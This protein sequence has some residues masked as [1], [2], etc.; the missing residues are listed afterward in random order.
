MAVI[1]FVFL[2]IASPTAAESFDLMQVPE[3]FTKQL[4]ASEPLVMDPVSFCFDDQGHILVAESFRQEHGVP[5]NRSSPFWLEDDLASQTIEDRLA[6]FE[7]WADQRKNGMDFYTDKQERIRRLTDRDKD[8]VFDMAKEF[9]AGFNDPLDGTGAGVLAMDGVVWF[10]NIPHL[11]RLHDFDEDGI[12]DRREVMYMGFGVRVALRGHDLHGL[13]L[14]L[15]GRLYWSIGDRGYHLELEDGRIFHSPGEGGVFRCELDGSNLEVFHHGLRNPQELAFDNFGNLFTGDNNSDDIDKARLVYCV[16]GG[17][18][19]WRMEYQTLFGD[20][21]RGPWVQEHG[22]DP[23]AQDRPAWILPAVDT[24]GSGPSGLVAYPGAGFPERYDN[25]FFMCDFR[26]AASHSSVLSFAVEPKGAG[27]TMVDLHP[28]V[29]HVLCTDVDFSYDGRMVV[30]DWG[31]GWTGNKEGRLYAAWSEEHVHEGDVS[32][33]F[34][35]GF[36]H[37]ANPEL[38]SMLSHIDRRVRIRSQL[39][40]AERDAIDALVQALHADDLLGR[41]HAMWGLAMTDRSGR[42]QMEHIV[43]LLKDPNSE[44]RAQACH[45]L[46]ESTYTDAFDAVAARIDDD[47]PRVSYFATIAASHLGNPENEVVAMVARNANKDVYLRHAGVVALA[48]C[49][50]QEALSSRTTHSSQAVRLA[51]VLALRKQGSALVANYLEDSDLDVATEAARAIHDVPIQGA[52]AALASSLPR[53][54]GMPWQRRAISACMRI[55]TGAEQVA[56]FAAD[57]TKN[58]AMRRVA[59]TSLQTWSTW[60]PGREIVEGRMVTTRPAG[61]DS[62]TPNIDDHIVEIVENTQ[63]SL[64]TEALR[65][66]QIYRTPL[67][68]GLE[69]SLLVDTSQPIDLREYCLR[70]LHDSAALEYG[71]QSSE[72]QLR[73][74]SRDLMLDQN[75]G[76]AIALLLEAVEEGVTGE[77]QAAITSLG[78]T[79]EGFSQI[80]ASDLPAELQLEYATAGNDPLMFGEPLESS[81]LARGGNEDA[82]RHVVYNNPAGQCFRCH[83]I[84]DQGGIAGPPLDGIADRLSE[85]QLL[86]A[87]LTPSDTVAEGFGEFSAMP[88]MG[89]L[90]NH[91]ELRDV[92]AY[93]KTLHVDEP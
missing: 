59:V 56:A 70:D 27:F 34:S 80:K 73:A 17:E 86:K 47:A 13:A 25:H 90:L 93:L 49:Q 33:I 8:G 42:Q 79:T 92:V 29:E 74:A 77:A 61:T 19:G 15:D 60:V 83:K 46:G 3:G 58:E 22:W 1:Q 50:D 2:L 89:G 91:R 88:P 54:K 37:R 10:T 85:Q 63:G 9:A 24:I 44:I 84:H 64:L 11:W 20:N 78:R 43:P 21:A 32:A 71:L 72:W 65:L 53:A 81:W 30:S 16:E 7:K 66:A 55:G 68:E 35:D 14:G 51:A 75:A 23:F 39:E 12:A 57:T 82:G 69:R 48:G 38:V 40:L 67:P 31:E 62:Q 36:H 5:D 87:L 4:I 76:R 6:M 26:G 52:M 41:I 45:I 28:F 18:T